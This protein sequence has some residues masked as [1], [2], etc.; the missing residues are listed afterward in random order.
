MSSSTGKPWPSPLPEIDFADLLTFPDWGAPERMAHRSATVIA[1][2]QLR[3]DTFWAAAAER[4]LTYAATAHVRGVR[5]QTA[6]PTLADAYRQRLPRYLDWFHLA[7]AEL[8]PDPTSHDR[9]RAIVA[10]LRPNA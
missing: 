4:S 2:H 10:A 8:L 3:L 5:L 9:L 7:A 1:D 6:N